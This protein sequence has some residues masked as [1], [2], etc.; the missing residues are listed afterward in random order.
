MKGALDGTSAV[1]GIDS[2][3]LLEKLAQDLNEEKAHLSGTRTGRL[4]IQYMAMVDLL[5]KFIKAE[6]LGKWALHLQS[7]FD[8]LPYF[9]ASGHNLYLKSVRLYLQKMSKLEVDH[10]DVYR[11]FVNG[12]HV[13]RRSDREWA[14]LSTDLAI[15]QCLMHNAQLE[16]H[17]G[18]DKR[19]RY[20]RSSKAD[21]GSIGTSLCRDKYCNARIFWNIIHH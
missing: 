4:W 19:K 3:V 16:D 13:I 20:D 6:R 1:E 8:M 10:P 12:L 21:L 2:H 5:R 17:W 7:M 15:E 18:F 11:H 9:A 14:G